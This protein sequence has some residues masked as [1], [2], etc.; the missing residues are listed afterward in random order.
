MQKFRT[1][2]I[3]LF[4]PLHFMK[5]V[6]YLCSFRIVTHYDFH[7]FVLYS[8]VTLAYF[9]SFKIQFKLEDEMDMRS[10]GHGQNGVE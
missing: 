4:S 5:F 1:H 3:F 2:N 7:F 8:I 10:G 9:S 6:V